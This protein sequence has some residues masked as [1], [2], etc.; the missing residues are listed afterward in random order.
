MVKRLAPAKD[1]GIN[2]GDIIYEVNIKKLTDIK[3]LIRQI[4]N[5]NGN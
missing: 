4:D 2:T 5:S 1:G 3:D